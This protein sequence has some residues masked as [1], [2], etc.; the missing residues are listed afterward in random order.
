MF[1]FSYQE[2]EPLKCFTTTVCGMVLG[3]PEVYADKNI[4]PKAQY[5]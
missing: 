4:W 3:T 2:A 5:F 1:L